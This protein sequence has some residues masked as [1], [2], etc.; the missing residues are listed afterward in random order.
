MERA[1]QLPPLRCVECLNA[2]ITAEPGSPTKTPSELA[3]GILTRIGRFFHAGPSQSGRGFFP[4]KAR[5]LSLGLAMQTV[6]RY[7][8]VAPT[9][10]GRG[11]RSLA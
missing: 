1:P 5:D 11:P 7:C 6:A 3:G 8:Q 9:L 10:V 2:R 4:V